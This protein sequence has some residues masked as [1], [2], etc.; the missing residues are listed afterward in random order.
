MRSSK[1]SA[2]GFRR[3]SRA[4]VVALSMLLALL[5]PA[6]WLHA[7]GQGAQTPPPVPKKPGSAPPP[8][9]G[10]APAKGT[11]GAAAP[12][13]GAAPA[14]AP[15]AMPQ[16]P[17]ENDDDPRVK[18]TVARAAAYLRSQNVASLGHLALVV[19]ALAKIHEKY[20]DIV[21]AEDPALA[22]AIAALRKFTEGGY[23]PQMSG[24]HDNYEAGVVAMG[25]TAADGQA[26]KSDIEAVAQY[27]LTKQRDYGAWSYDGQTGDTSQTQYAV[28]GLWEA[29]S[30]A[31]VNIPKTAW[32]RVAQWLVSRQNADGS[33]AYHPP[34]PQPGQAA[35]GHGTHT[36]TV[37]C[38]GSL[39]ICRD[40]LPGGKRKSSRGVVLQVQDEDEKV[41]PSFKAATSPD[42]VNAAIARANEW[43][44]N[45]YTIDKAQGESDSGGGQWKYYYLYALERYG[46]LSGQKKIA[47]HDWYDEGAQMLIRTQRQDGAWDGGYNNVCDAA[48]NVLFLIRSTHISQKIHNRRLGRG[49]LISGRGLPKN[50]ADMEQTAGGLKA[51]AVTGKIGDLLG[52]VESGKAEELEAVAL[53]ALA[54]IYEKKWSAGGDEGDKLRKYYQR[55][56]ATKNPE[57]IKFAMKALAL[58]GDYRVVPLLIDGMYYEDDAEVQ[59]AAHQAL[60]LI[61]R[62]FNGFGAIYP[63]EATLEEWKAEID[64]W[65]NWYRSVRPEYVFE[66]D[67]D[68]DVDKKVE[69]TKSAEDKTAKPKSKALTVLGMMTIDPPAGFEWKG[70]RSAELDGKKA[71]AY[72]AE[73]PE[74]KDTVLTLTFAADQRAPGDDAQR[75]AQIKRY[76]DEAQQSLK[77]AGYR[78][79]EVTA[80]KLDPP[81][82]NKVVFHMS[83][84][85]PEGPL[86]HFRF[87]CVYSK[88]AYFFQAMALSADEADQ[89][90]ATAD[91]L[92][93]F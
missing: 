29:G 52:K 89:L 56:V 8:V 20:P 74:A 58:S 45:H 25:L 23:K 81:I 86:R 3:Y 18:A 90:V 71:T 33:F 76:F 50:L 85:S 39:Y 47:G 54:K 35:T 80:P 59:L 66:D 82:G 11:G 67:V 53:G 49:T 14:T 4:A 83:G 51:K 13:G 70:P 44:A 19:H 12:A 79:I 24:G 38:L 21:A 62:K 68:V 93:E 55:G 87:L 73:N 7:Q 5:M 78:K 1:Y 22:R 30:G 88:F 26:F 28:L 48:F 92:T 37:A 77:D 60:C 32:D 36:M 72:R 75:S 16:G 57:L 40:H 2:A 31:G 15:T 61:S 27:I 84:V 42:A 64:R 10:A 46:T 34:D 69:L 91:S 9:G 17:I 6:V 63:E 41:D 43:F 65:K